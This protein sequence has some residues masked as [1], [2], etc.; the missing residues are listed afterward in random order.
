[1]I[2]SAKEII[3]MDNIQYKS[4]VEILTAAPKYDMKDSDNNSYRCQVHTVSVCLCWH[5]P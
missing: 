5:C 1:M 3:I 4:N 2:M